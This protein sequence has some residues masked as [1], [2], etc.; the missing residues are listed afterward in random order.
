MTLH[1]SE[2][3]QKPRCLSSC[4]LLCAFCLVQFP[5]ADKMNNLNPV[6]IRQHRLW[7]VVPAHNLLIQFD[8]YAFRRQRQFAYQLA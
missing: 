8:R 7:P 5:A 2:L 4:F 1:L 6:A 3:K